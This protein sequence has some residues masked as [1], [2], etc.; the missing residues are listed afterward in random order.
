MPSPPRSTSTSTRQRRHSSRISP[1]LRKKS[2]PKPPT[3]PPTKPSRK[4]SSTRGKKGG[5]VLA[6]VSV[7]AGLLFL[8]QFLKRRKT[9]SKKVKFSKKR[10]FTKKV[11][12]KK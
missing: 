2:P 3:K 11:N 6:D 7:P 4:S 9:V 5:S 1:M 10:A 8:N 12:K